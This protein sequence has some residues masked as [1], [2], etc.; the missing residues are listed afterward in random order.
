MR[1]AFARHGEPDGRRGKREIR[2]TREKIET[3]GNSARVPEFTDVNG[4]GKEKER[5]RGKGSAGNADDIAA[6]RDIT[7]FVSPKT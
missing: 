4:E 2:G 1:A 6:Q 7:S 5:E 3:V